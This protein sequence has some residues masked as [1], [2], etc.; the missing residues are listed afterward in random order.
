M[1]TLKYDLAKQVIDLAYSMDMWV[2]GG[3]VRDV[4]VRG[5]RVFGDLDLCC[6]QRRTHP[7]HFIRAL[8]TFW[9]VTRFRKISAY[10]RTVYRCVVDDI[11]SVDLLVYPET[12]DDWCQE[13]VVDCTCNLLYSKRNVHLGLRYVP[14]GYAHDPHPMD[15]ILDMTRHGI[16]ERIWEPPLSTRGTR[17]YDVCHRIYQLVKRGW[18]LR[19]EIMNPSMSLII[20]N[21]AFEAPV[22]A[23]CRDTR[24]LSVNRIRKICMPHIDQRI[25]TQI[26]T[27]LEDQH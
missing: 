20:M 6:S 22:N 24:T 4:T 5:Q 11:L 12:F 18:T 26:L 1:E 8:G 15:T 9:S 17:V 25:I 16:F 14:T 13:H 3:Y 27:F 2:F 21:D 7:M 23:V 19:G 10:F